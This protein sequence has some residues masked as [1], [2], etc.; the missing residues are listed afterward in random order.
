MNPDRDRDAQAM[1]EVP[2]VLVLWLMLEVL[3]D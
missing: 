3:Q 1:L 2:E